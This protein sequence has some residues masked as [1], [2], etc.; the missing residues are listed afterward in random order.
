MGSSVLAAY[1]PSWKI[2]KGC[3]PSDLRLD[4]LDYVCYA[5]IRYVIFNSN[6]YHSCT[7]QSKAILE[8]SLRVV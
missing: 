5:F 4:L 6:V 3:K 7:F 1:Y 2:Y 8:F